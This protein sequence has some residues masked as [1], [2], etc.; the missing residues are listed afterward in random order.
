MRSQKMLALAAIFGLGAVLALARLS[1]AETVKNADPMK[2]GVVVEL[3]TMAKTVTVKPTDQAGNPSAT[4]TP[5]EITLHWDATTRVEGTLKKGE[6][7]RYTA[8]EKDGRLLASWIQVGRTAD[9]K[10]NEK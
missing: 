5:S 9:P 2:S 4:A 8:S 3:D 10:P 7:I 1:P 6:S